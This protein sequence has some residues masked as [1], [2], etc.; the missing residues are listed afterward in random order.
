MITDE[1]EILIEAAIPEIYRINAFRISG[2]NINATTR[3]ITN[4]LK[5]NKM[6][7]KYSDESTKQKSPFPIVPSPDTH[8]IR[9]AL[10]RLRD[11]ETRL[12]DEFFWFWP[13][14]IAAYHSDEALECL[15]RNDISS[16]ESKWLEYEA[17]VTESNVSRHNLA[18]LSHLQALDF[19]LNGKNLTATE[20]QK[21]DEYW[22]N[23]FIRWKI[24]FDHEG[25]W[26]RLT[27][28]VR[29]MNDPRLTTGFV[30][31]LR[32]S[33]PSALL[34]INATLALIAV[35]KGDI[36][37]AKRYIQLL[38]KSGFGTEASM[39][40]IKRVVDPVRNRI[41]II[42][43]S[44]TNDSYPDPKSH[45]KASEKLINQTKK[46]LTILDVL[47]PGESPLREAAH[48]EVSLAALNL[49]ISYVNNNGEDLERA[50]KIIEEIKFLVLGESAGTRVRMN[51]NIIQKNYEYNLVYNRCFYCKENIPD[52]SS[53]VSVN[54]HG[55]VNKNY[56]TRQITWRY[57]KV[58]V[59]RC[60]NCKK[61][62]SKR[63]NIL[64]LGVFISL[65][66]GIVIGTAVHNVLAFL[67]V[68]GI[69]I[70]FSISKASLSK[71]IIKKNNYNE[72]PQIKELLEKGWKW[73]ERPP[74]N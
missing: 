45:L 37:N 30:K 18:V 65:A 25:F 28:R 42:C 52:E 50:L 58:K 11:P 24:L 56:F 34:Q 31:R 74:S 46:L 48:D 35:E 69:G 64:G 17:T 21:R 68:A 29:Q 10:H 16:A 33:L 27:A 23:T 43:K 13:H 14:N 1:C 47:L 4:Q 19:E 67:F 39:T 54:M 61:E 70:A 55:D 5:K 51:Y 44:Y 41:K 73:G 63:E 66:I 60:S 71:N 6:V 20:I 59:P 9:Q 38:H 72:F 22:K 7:E 32:E 49:I 62:H 3:D 8:Q 40:A 26:S 36:T 53:A 57:L 2:L 15:A 12:I